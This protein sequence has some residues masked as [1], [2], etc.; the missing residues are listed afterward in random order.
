MN[1]TNLDWDD[2][3]LFL[4]IARG[5]G[6]APATRST[7]KSAPTLGRRMVQLERRLGK[8]LFVR[9]PKG[10]DLTEEGEA[11]LKT[12]AELEA[13][14]LALGD[15]QDG[16]IPSV[17]ISAG[18][19]VSRAL[20]ARMDRIAGDEQVRLHLIAADEVLNIGHRAATIGVRNHRP[21]A[22]TLAGRKIGPVSFAVYAR[23]PTVTRWAQVLGPTPSAQWVRAQ[24]E[25]PSMLEVSHPRNAL[26]LARAGLARVV[27]PTFVGETEQNLVRLGDPI[28]EL[29]HEQWL[30]MHHEDRH[31][32]EIRAV[33]N[34]TFQILSEICTDHR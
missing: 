6:L 25:A 1:E 29:E 9:K 10:Y 32:P 16:P 12:A 4:A 18:A 34:R 20:C 19:W 33:I 22:P 3:R 15:T 11:F 30:V 23:D 27:L 14:I 8:D 5:G 21:T 26:D 17:K 28:A 2:L 13:R 24:T 31:I 7:G